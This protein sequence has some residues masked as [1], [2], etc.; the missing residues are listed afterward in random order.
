[1]FFNAVLCISAIVLTA[2]VPQE[3][4]PVSTAIRVKKSITD[5]APFT[6]DRTTALTFTLISN[7]IVT[8]LRKMQ[9]FLVALVVLATGGSAAPLKGL[10]KRA[11]ICNMNTCVGALAPS[12]PMACNPAVA[13]TGANT[14]FNAVCFAAAAKGTAAFPTAC[15]P[16]AAQFGITDPA[17]NAQGNAN[18]QAPGAGSPG[19]VGPRAQFGIPGPA[20][21]AQGN[22]NRPNAYGAL[23]RGPNPVA[24][25][26]RAPGAG[27]PRAVG[28]RAQFC[29]PGPANN[30]QGNPNRPNANG[31]PPNGANPVTTNN[32]A[33]GPGSPAPAGPGAQFG[34]PGP[35]NNAQ[36]NPNR[37]NANGAPARGANAGSPGAVGPRA[38]ACDI[39]ACVVALRPSFPLCAPA[40]AQ[41]GA[42]TPFNAACLAAAAK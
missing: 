13:Q 33:P 26:N 6:V 19:A 34:V 41:L 40:V 27:S 29:I 30:A 23:P 36:G 32:Q 31:V 8:T 21:N 35:A 9:F 1:M 12:F 17:N 16:C 24:T 38:S 15:T 18:N 37:P 14:P 7:P 5:V 11:G 39:N 20:N 22:P 42:D 28:P 10:S 4:P 25:N 3:A 2:A